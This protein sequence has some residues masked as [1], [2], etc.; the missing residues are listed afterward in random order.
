MAKS[1]GKIMLGEGVLTYNNGSSDVV[2]GYTR[3]GTFNDN[4]NI[5]HIAADGKK[6]NTKGDAVID[7]ISPTLEFALVQMESALLDVV[8]ANSTV[9]DA[10]GIKTLKRKV[11]AVADDQYLANVMYVGATTDGKAITI[12]LLEALGEAP[13]NFA[14]GD[15]TEVEIPT[16]FTGNYADDSTEFAPYEVIMDETV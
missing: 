13:V 9:T 16:M 15:K 4:I 8:F 10:T 3:G 1:F 2:L 11:G 5:R 12:K 6:G 7:E 14:F